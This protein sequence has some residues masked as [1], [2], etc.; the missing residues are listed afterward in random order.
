MH[1]KVRANGR[2]L[3][4]PLIETAKNSAFPPQ[5]STTSFTRPETIRI[6]P[7]GKKSDSGIE[8]F[9]S[10]SITG[11]FR[12][13]GALSSTAHSSNASMLRTVATTSYRS[14]S[15]CS[16]SHVTYVL[17]ISGSQIG[18]LQTYLVVEQRLA[19]RVFNLANLLEQ[20]SVVE[21]TQAIFGLQDV[22]LPQYERLLYSPRCRSV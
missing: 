6:G 13:S 9:S 7:M 20:R 3:I 5:R 4:A 12:P 15:S 2:G 8:L 1:E 22:Q 21:W 18:A 17:L 11:K 16:Q 10:M 14:E 19:N